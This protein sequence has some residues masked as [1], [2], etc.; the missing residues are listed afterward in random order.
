MSNLGFNL[1]AVYNS[2]NCCRYNFSSSRYFNANIGVILKKGSFLGH[3]S[4]NKLICA[5]MPAVRVVRN[6]CKITSV[7]FFL[8]L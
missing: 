1:D 8:H 2:G 5:L 7:V 3:G 4:V 6:H